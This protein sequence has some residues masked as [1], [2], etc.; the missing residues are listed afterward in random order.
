M[1]VSVQIDT[2]QFQDMLDRLDREIRAS[3]YDEI[4]RAEVQAVLSKAISLTKKAKKAQ[5]TETIRRNSAMRR[6]DGWYKPDGRSAR[7]RNWRLKD[8]E[9]AEYQ[10]RVAAKIKEL[11]ARAGLSAQGWIEIAENLGL[12]VKAPAGVR[13]ARVNGSPVNHRVQGN[14][15]QVGPKQISYTLSY[16]NPSG[17]FAGAT[18]ALSRAVNGRTRYF[19]Q[20]IKRGVFDDVRTIAAKYP[21]IRVTPR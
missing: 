20:N 15:R 18:S 11:R 10:K 4:L 12:Q 2:T 21:G 7:K 5:I 16:S 9:W 13:K 14:R 1:S 19:Q 3:E 8:S 6:R 17:R